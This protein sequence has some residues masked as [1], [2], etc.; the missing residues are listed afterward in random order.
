MLLIYNWF[1]YY[2]KVI[3]ADKGRYSFSLRNIC[4][5]PV[6]FLG[7]LIALVNVSGGQNHVKT[8]HEAEQ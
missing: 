7:T 4:A 8:R 6:I 5:K 2:V 3:V 1:I